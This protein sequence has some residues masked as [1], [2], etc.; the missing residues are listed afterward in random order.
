MRVGGL[1]QAAFV[2]TMLI[3]ALPSFHPR[4]ANE[5]HGPTVVRQLE[6]PGF[7]SL[8]YGNRTPISVGIAHCM[9]GPSLA[10]S[11]LSARMSGDFM[12]DLD[13]GFRDVAHSLASHD[14]P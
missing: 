3:P 11:T 2:L 10:T 5:Q 4:R 12:D 6:P 1:V 7:L 14:P 9:L 8:H 13:I